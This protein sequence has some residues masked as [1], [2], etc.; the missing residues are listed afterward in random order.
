MF[1]H[2]L[3]F[4]SN[5][6]P[7][8]PIPRKESKVEKQKRL[9]QQVNE[10]CTILPSLRRYTLLL[11]KVQPFIIQLNTLLST[12]CPASV[13]E[14]IDSLKDNSSKRTTPPDGLAPDIALETAYDP[15]LLIETSIASHADFDSL[16]T[17]IEDALFGLFRLANPSITIIPAPIPDP[18]KTKRRVN[19]FVPIAISRFYRTVSP[20]NLRELL[21][22]ITRPASVGLPPEQCSQAVASLTTLLSLNQTKEETDA[23]TVQADQPIPDFVPRA[24]SFL[25]QLLIETS[26]ALTSLNSITERIAT[27]HLKFSFAAHT[28]REQASFHSTASP[29]KPPTRNNAP[30]PLSAALKVKQTPS[31]YIDPTLPQDPDHVT[32]LQYE[33][34]TFTPRKPKLDP[35]KDPTIRQLTDPNLAQSAGVDPR[36]AELH[37][38]IAPVVKFGLREK[39]TGRL[40]DAL[41]NQGIERIHRFYGSGEHDRESMEPGLIQ[42]AKKEEAKA[43]E[44]EQRQRR[45]LREFNMS[46]ESPNTEVVYTVKRK[47]VDPSLVALEA[48]FPLVARADSKPPTL[49]HT[50]PPPETQ[51]EETTPPSM[52]EQRFFNIDVLAPAE[53]EQSGDEQVDQDS[54]SSLFDDDEVEEKEEG[55][56]FDMLR[57]ARE[58]AEGKGWITD[59]D[60]LNKP[61]LAI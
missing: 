49:S 35:M 53:T 43:Y 51:E 18:S 20:L 19:Q 54:F 8:L 48:V 9:R 37:A 17:Q 11:G 58:E 56:L 27:L 47:I 3:R 15:A 39:E 1:T 23:P 55:L 57:K 44:E 46:V 21:K 34:G 28:K 30:N 32:L 24:V 2:A 16:H 10:L 50:P 33:N 25:E 52:T 41:S 26:V 29:V 6:N 45:L 5:V 36:L 42:Q 60:E 22:A 38:K 61:N 13:E 12:L 31:P 14:W 4:M 59:Q 7:A 40:P